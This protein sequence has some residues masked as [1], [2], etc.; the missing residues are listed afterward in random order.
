MSDAISTEA[1][2]DSL[3]DFQRDTVEHVFRRLWTDADATRRFLVA[4]EVGLG[5]TMVAKG[6]IAKTVEYLRGKVG[7]IDVVYICSNAQ[8]A[9][10]NLSRLNALGGNE[11][12]HAD[13]LTMLPAVI[14]SLRKHDV[15]F[16][17]FTPGTSFQVGQRSGRAEERVMLYW[18]LV[19]AW[20]AEVRHHTRWKRF[21]EGWVSRDNFERHLKA[22]N[23]KQLDTK[24]C[25]TFALE[26][27]KATGP[28][29]GRL[30]D[31]LRECVLEFNYLRGKPSLPVR[32]RRDALVGRLRHLV[33]RA[34]VTHLE[35][36][37]IILDE[38]QRFKDLLRTDDDTA[39]LDESAEL[40]NALMD[41]PDARVLMLSATPYKMYTLPDEPEGDD[42]YRDFTRT[43]SVLGGRERAARVEAGLREMRETILG[44]GDVEQARA[45]RDTAESE[46]RKIMS[47]TERLA[48]TPDR[49]GMLAERPLAAAR[50]TASD[51]RTWLFVDNVARLVDRHDVFEYW[52][53]TPYPLSIMERGSYQLR[54]RFE[55]AIERG[56]AGVADALRGAPLLSRETLAEYG[57]VEPGNAKMRG[58]LHDV[59]DRGAWQL[60]W[61]PPSL[62]YYPLGGAYAAPELQSFTKRLVFSAWTVVPKAIASLMSYEAERRGVALLGTKRGYADRVSRPLQFRLS[63]DERESG[64]TVLA[65]MYPSL[66]L[67]RVGD[68]LAVARGEGVDVVETVASRVRELLAALPSAEG[69]VD[70]RWYWAAPLLLDRA[71]AAAESAP[72]DAVLRSLGDESADADADDDADAETGGEGGGRA[73]EGR[74]ALDAHLLRAAQLDVELAERPLGAQPDDLAEVL[75][76]LAVAGPGV[77]ALRALSRVSGGPAVL[78]DVERRRRAFDIAGGLRSLFNRP[79]IITLLRAS[80][81]NYWRVVLQQCIDGC[82][83]AVLDEYAHVL[84]ESCGLQ[85]ADGAR[86]AEVLAANMVEALTTRTASARIEHFTVDGGR[87]DTAETRV[88]THFASRMG[89]AVTKSAID[90]G[91]SIR[92]AFNSPFRPFVLA[93]TSAGQEGLDFHTYSH[94]VVHWNLPSNPV[95]LEQREGRVHRYKGHAVRKNVAAEYGSAALAAPGDD[96]WTAMFD[97][98]VDD[99]PA[100][101]SDITPFWVFTRPGGAVIERYVP[102]QPLSR[103]SAQLERLKRTVGA[104]RLVMGQPRQE[105]LLRYIGER[106][107]DVDWMRIDLSPREE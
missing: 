11:L 57:A 72:F 68:P 51:L 47:R 67:A 28:N 10:Q 42:H 22:F 19:R 30:A 107:G 84:V 20:G 12:R 53:S 48:S 50:V 5:K 94:A 18:M 98:A 102:A 104:Y 96:P 40:A 38:F 31:E 97:A 71:H 46:L 41:Y 60:A 13:R 45:A 26:V 73:A 6:V 49:D 3:K 1:V 14:G 80:D 23:E 86:R 62:P 15:N 37:L 34:S 27:E 4:D 33:A 29:G 103:E 87:I 17:S 32:M 35:P 69:P 55:A 76:Q 59:L 66:V 64:M 65:L 78:A 81:D 8:I 105:D 93:T 79:E 16:V 2:L 89:D 52:R 100:E 56:D 85:D 90:R 36:D 7:R 75:A 82:L 9:R 77:T 43:V 106:D 39:P 54:R 25:D 91:S 58:L 92:T 63:G 24:L 88:R 95:D 101:A 21:F 70:Q 83:Q 74:R 99:R 61:I 44:G